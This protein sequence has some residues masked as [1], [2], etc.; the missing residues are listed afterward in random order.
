MAF[1]DIFFLF[2]RN[3]RYW[4]SLLSP[5]TI[6]T[7]SVMDPVVQKE[8]WPRFTGSSAWMIGLAIVSYILYALI[9]NA[10]YAL[11]LMLAL[12][13]HEMGHVLAMWYYGLKVRGIYA[14]PLL[15]AVV[16]SKD[17]A[18]SYMATSVI[19]LMG[20]G[21][22]YAGAAATYILYWITGIPLIAGMAGWMVLLNLMNL[23]PIVPFDGGQ[24]WTI[25]LSRFSR[26]VRAILIGIP[27][28]WIGYYVYK[29]HMPVLWLVYALSPLVIGIK[30]Y[31]HVWRARDRRRILH[32]LCDAI[33]AENT[34]VPVIRA[35]ID[36]L[37]IEIWEY[38]RRGFVHPLFLTRDFEEQYRRAMKYP[39]K[40]TQDAAFRLSL[41]NIARRQRRVLKWRNK[42]FDVTAYAELD[43]GVNSPFYNSSLVY[44]LDD[45]PEHEPI[46]RIQ[47]VMAITGYGLLV[48]GL[49]S[50]FWQVNRVPH[51]FEELFK[52][53]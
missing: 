9:L 21:L 5:L 49:L 20:P 34:S 18:P 38:T 47:L 22:G 53:M 52:I 46:T 15:G 2:D 1:I 26:P 41:T 4:D 40:L 10:K 42:I 14:I 32:A 39:G 28:V 35:R 51:A 23:L 24:V 43:A 25:I 29:A 6:R 3:L 19:A 30:L 50:L 37:M 36:R 31:V 16:F 48:F 44:Y 8:P 13:I 27:L 12:C 11:F 17:S 33:G 45:P 7:E